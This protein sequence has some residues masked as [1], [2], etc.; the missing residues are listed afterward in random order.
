MKKI[1][2]YITIIFFAAGCKV[3]DSL[4]NDRIE[5]LK[6]EGVNLKPLNLENYTFYKIEKYFTVEGNE[7]YKGPDSLYNGKKATRYEMQFMAV[8]DSI[9][10]INRDRNVINFNY[11]APFVFYNE[12]YYDYPLY[13]RFNLIN[14]GYINYIQFGKLN[15]DE[16]RLIRNKSVSVWRVSFTP[17]DIT[18]NAVTFLDKGK[19]KNDDPRQRLRNPVM[20]KKINSPL[21]VLHPKVEDPI[22]QGNKGYLVEPRTL[23]YDIN[24]NDFYF[25]FKEKLKE[26]SNATWIRY[27]NS[28]VKAKYTE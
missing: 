27:S 9:H 12:Y 26:D 10:A 5:E 3:Y 17:N 25:Q 18:V 28:R 15:H 19:V 6:N 4:T 24:N 8:E 2:V 16:I 23:Y 7:I 13:D 1:A 21:I 11:L 14:L 22:S 20:Y